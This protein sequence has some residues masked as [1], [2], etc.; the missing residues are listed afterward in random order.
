MVY[1]KGD[2]NEELESIKDAARKSANKFGLRVGVVTEPR[3]VKKLKK[4][5][6]W[7]GEASLNSIILKRYDGE[8]FNLDLLQMNIVHNAFFWIWKKS[9]KDVE[10]LSE[11]MFGQ[12]NMIGQGVV[13]SFVDFESQNE[14]VAYESRRLV[15]TVLP[16]VA[17]ALFKAMVV[18]YID[19]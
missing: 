3:L 6:S 9:V 18:I 17:K 11:E 16:I 14:T 2:Y 1:N 7:F 5:T 19:V 12:V 13:M 15:N 8:I 10:E 4:E